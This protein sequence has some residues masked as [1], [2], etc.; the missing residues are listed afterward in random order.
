MRRVC[1]YAPGSPHYIADASGAIVG[2]RIDTKRGEILK[3]IMQSAAMYFVESI[4]YLRGLGINLHEMAATGGGAKSAAWLQIQ[5]DVFGIPFVRP[6][7]SEAGLVGTTILAGLGTGVYG[8][9]AEGAERFVRRDRVFEPNAE[10]HRFYRELHGRYRELYHQ[11]RFPDANGQHPGFN[12]RD[13]RAGGK[14]GCQRCLYSEHHSG[15]S[16]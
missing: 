5:A 16:R 9:V 15:F 13:H 1:W 10:R 3:A 7:V 14:G 8:S 2:L 12:S 4:D 11:H 6:Q